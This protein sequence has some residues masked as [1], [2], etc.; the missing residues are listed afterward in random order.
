MYFPGKEVLAFPSSHNITGKFVARH[1][2]LT[3]SLREDLSASVVPKLSKL[4][5][6]HHFHGSH[7]ITE[8]PREGSRVP[9]HPRLLQQMQ[10]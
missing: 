10:V 5:R 3:Q 6:G 7:Q 2:G 8:L 1:Q 9:L 4:P